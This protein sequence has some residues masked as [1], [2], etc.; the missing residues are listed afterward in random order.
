MHFY[1]HAARVLRQL[2]MYGTVPT[3]VGR[4]KAQSSFHATASSAPAVLS[5]AA[6]SYAACSLLPICA[7]MT[8]CSRLRWHTA[9]CTAHAHGRRSRRHPP[10]CMSYLKH[11]PPGMPHLTHLFTHGHPASGG[12]EAPN[13]SSICLPS[14]IFAAPNQHP[15]SVITSASNPG[16]QPANTA[17]TGCMWHLQGGACSTAVGPALNAACTTHPPTCTSLAAHHD[18]GTEC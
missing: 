18:A 8:I 17:P 12:L 7:V 2:P 3:S 11:D 1:T 15:Q 5:H 6:S 4:R 16:L 10:A 9:L 13:T 14:C